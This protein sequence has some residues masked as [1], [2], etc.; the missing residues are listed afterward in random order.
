MIR[1]RITW[2]TALAAVTLIGASPAVAQ[3]RPQPPGAASATAGDG[4]NELP[5][6]WR[7]AATDEGNALE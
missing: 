1:A 2:A 7:I 3:A 4:A 5:P 6:G